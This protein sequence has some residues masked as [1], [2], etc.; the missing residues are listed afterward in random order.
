MIFL[1]FIFGLKLISGLETCRDLVLS[2]LGDADGPYAALTDYRGRPDFFRE[3]G[4]YN[5]YGEENVGVCYWRIDN[6]QSEF[7]FFISYDDCSY[8]PIDIE[9]DWFIV[10]DGLDPG[11][12]TFS[13]S[14]DYPEPKQTWKLYLWGTLVTLAVV[15]ITFYGHVL[16]RRNRIMKSKRECA[17]C[18]KISN[19]GAKVVSRAFKRK[20]SGIGPTTVND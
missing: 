17:V 4:I 19:E 3:D 13:M 14:C 15:I 1:L 5:L 8:H 12:I 16:C 11:N 20:A 10:V 6:A 9:S 18:R 2:G 7:P